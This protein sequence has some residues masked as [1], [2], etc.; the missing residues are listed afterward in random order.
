VLVWVR[1]RGGDGDRGKIS[2]REKAAFEK[3]GNLFLSF[4]GQ[5][6]SHFLFSKQRRKSYKNT[7]NRLERVA[8]F[9]SH[10]HPS[11]NLSDGH[12]PNLPPSYYF[13]YI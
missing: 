3:A 12:R 10:S 13:N 11:R 4:D 5:E 9:I 7:K 1:T 2:G 6:E 8:V